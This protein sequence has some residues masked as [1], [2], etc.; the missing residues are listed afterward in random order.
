LSRVVWK[1]G[2]GWDEETDE[3]EEG[4]LETRIEPVIDVLGHFCCWTRW[5]KLLHSLRYGVE[6]VRT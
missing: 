3:K 4:K 6:L 1:A 2:E 5:E